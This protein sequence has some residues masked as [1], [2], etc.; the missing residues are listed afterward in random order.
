MKHIEGTFK[1]KKNFN[2]YYQ[3]WIP[4][5][6]ARAVILIA[7]GVNEH[8]GRYAEIA[9]YFTSRNYAVYGFDY[10][11]HGKSEGKRGYVEHFSYYIDDLK[12]FYNLASSFY[13]GRK[14]FLFG[15]SMGAAVSLAYTIHNSQ[16]LSGIMISAVP[17]RVSPRLPVALIVLLMPLSLLFPKLGI[18]KLDTSTIIRDEAEM[19]LL[20][21]DPLVYWGKLSARLGIELLRTIHKL[22]NQLRQIQIPAL[23]MHGTADRLSYPEGSQIVFNKLGSPDKTL[24]FYGGFYH[25]I[26]K[27][28]E[29]LRVFEDTEIWL[30]HLV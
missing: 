17:I 13:P 2:L 20:H 3:G 21:N 9:G 14:V 1:G 28:P 5:R 11:G 24:K 18:S 10:R 15:H 16:T 25:E 12:T 23:I 27:D 4:E 22:E 7:H 26:I 8:C 29:R 6:N 30:N 19:E